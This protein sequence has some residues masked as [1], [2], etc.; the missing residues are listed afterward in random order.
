MRKKLI[1][2]N[3][4]NITQSILSKYRGDSKLLGIILNLNYSTTNDENLF[5]KFVLFQTII[6]KLIVTKRITKK[7]GYKTTGF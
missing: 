6:Q 3:F 7:C 2:L 4:L 1:E 5:K